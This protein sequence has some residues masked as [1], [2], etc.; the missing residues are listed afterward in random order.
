[1]STPG[2]SVESFEKELLQKFRKAKPE[3]QEGILEDLRKLHELY[4]NH[5]LSLAA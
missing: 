5:E 2:H 4:P 1:M 3:E